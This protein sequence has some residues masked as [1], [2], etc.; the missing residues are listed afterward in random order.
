[1]YTGNQAI[2]SEIDYDS[3]IS[4]ANLN[5]KQELE[6]LVLEISEVKQTDVVNYRIS[7]VYGA[8]LT[9]GFIPES[10]KSLSDNQPIRIYKKLDLVR[11]YLYVDDL[12]GA[13]F[14]LRLHGCQD[15]VINISTGHGV[16]LS[17]VIKLIK[18]STVKDLKLLEI[19]EPLGTLAR[20][21]L[22]CKKLKETIPWKPQLLDMTLGRLVQG[23]V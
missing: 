4:G 13:L 21:V 19:E 7:N 12:I 5:S 9:Q 1:V 10:L 11:D 8:G 23:W 14:D 2:F 15:E 3:R 22:S 17:D 20:S 16:A 18:L 6:E